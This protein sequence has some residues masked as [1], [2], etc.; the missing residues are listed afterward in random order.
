MRKFIVALGLKSLTI[1]ALIALVRLV[2][3]K[4]TGNSTFPNPIPGLPMLSTAADDLEAKTTQVAETKILLTQLVTEQGQLRKNLENEI[5]K[6][7]K[8]VSIIADGDKAKIESAGMP[9]SDEPSPVSL[10]QVTG[11]SL[12]HG[13]IHGETDAHWNAMRKASGYEVETSGT[14][15]DEHGI[16]PW[17]HYDHTQASKITIENRQPGSILWIRVTATGHSDTKGAPSAPA[18]I[19]VG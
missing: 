17:I 9:A 15:P 18:F 14:A 6:E 8:Y 19:I 11:L 1:A 10:G 13:D 3:T 4:M 5:T 12:T 2:V 16:A 7:G